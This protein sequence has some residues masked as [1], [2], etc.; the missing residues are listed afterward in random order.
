MFRI[1]IYR[2]VRSHAVQNLETGIF[3][4]EV[5]RP[6]CSYSFQGD[7]PASVEAAFHDVVDEF[8]SGDYGRALFDSLSTPP[9]DA[10][11]GPVDQG[12]KH[13]F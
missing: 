4:G 13:D 9:S 1:F 7:T 6:G 2:G 5:K 12:E 10:E 3:F 8:L 11:A